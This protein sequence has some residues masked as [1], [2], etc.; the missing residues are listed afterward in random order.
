MAFNRLAT[1]DGTRETPR[2]KVL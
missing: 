1:R 2:A